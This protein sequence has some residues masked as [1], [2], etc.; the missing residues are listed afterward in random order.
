MQNT[1]S[2]NPRYYLRDKPSYI[3]EKACKGGNLEILKWLNDQNYETSEKSM[4]IAIKCGNEQIV[5]RLL[6]NRVSYREKDF[7]V[8]AKAGYFDV[9][10]KLYNTEYE[11]EVA[12]LAAEAGNI[13]QSQIS[14]NEMAFAAIRKGQVEVADYLLEKGWKLKPNITNKAA[15]SGKV[16]VMQWAIDNGGILTVK[17]MPKALWHRHFKLCKWLKANGCPWDDQTFTEAAKNGDS[18]EFL[19]WLKENGCP[20]STETS[21]VA[22][23]SSNYEIFMWLVKNGCPLEVQTTKNQKLKKTIMSADFLNFAQEESNI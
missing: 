22:A 14:L 18:L 6:K 8:A 21:C 17:T 5:D 20:W 11:N 23:E 16:E 2:T 4:S 19:Q 7:K 15:A 1:L 10:K 13:I 3:H 9:A 12:E